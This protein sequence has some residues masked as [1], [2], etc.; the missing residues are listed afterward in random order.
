MLMKLCKIRYLN[1]RQI[2]K[3]PGFCECRNQLQ[4]TEDL[5][6]FLKNPEHAFVDI[7][8]WETRL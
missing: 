4:I 1:I 8:K 3:K 7:G 6:K 2:C 5:N